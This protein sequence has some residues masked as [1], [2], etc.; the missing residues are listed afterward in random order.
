[1]KGIRC[2]IQSADVSQYIKMYTPP[3]LQTETLYYGDRKISIRTSVLEEKATACNMLCCY[4][5]ELEV[6]FFPYVEQV[7]LRHLCCCSH[8]TCTMQSKASCGLLL[9]RLA[10]SDAVQTCVIQLQ[11]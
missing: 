6:G 7:L 9:F 10:A 8:C 4:A 1:M 3:V 11:L 5:D 2:E